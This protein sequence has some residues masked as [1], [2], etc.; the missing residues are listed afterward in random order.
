MPRRRNWRPCCCS[1]L[2]VP[3]S[4]YDIADQPACVTNYA[5]TAREVYDTTHGTA[6]QP[7]HV[8]NCATTARAAHGTTCGTAD[9]PVHATH[10]ATTAR[11][12]YDTGV[13]D[14]P[15][16]IACVTAARAAHGNAHGT[17]DA[18]I[19]CATTARAACDNSCAADTANYATTARA[20][21]D[22]GTASLRGRAQPLT[23]PPAPLPGS[24]RPPPRH[25]CAC[26]RAE[27]DHQTPTSAP[28][29]IHRLIFT[30]AMWC[31]VGGTGP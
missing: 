18:P 1:W 16:R 20:V 17:A 9:P 22:N 27:H 2:A 14:S 29:P 25:H 24:M 5:T 15:A 6:D 23:A 3:A 10:C 7:A 12:A 21:Y 8:T 28:G 4:Y 19:H 13:A 31:Y 26:A 11:A 30:S